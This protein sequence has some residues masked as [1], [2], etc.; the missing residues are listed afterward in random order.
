MEVIASY[1]KIIFEF[2]GGRKRVASQPARSM[3]KPFYTLLYVF[4]AHRNSFMDISI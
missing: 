2:V 4:S 1:F 3:M